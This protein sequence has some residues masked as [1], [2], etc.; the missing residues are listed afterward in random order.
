MVI[1]SHRLSA[2]ID[3]NLIMVMDRGR[4]VDLAP[5][6]TLLERCTIYRSLWAQQNRHLGSG[7]GART[8]ALV[9]VSDPVV[10]GAR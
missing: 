7:M 6:R 5:H 3:C 2:L 8:A 9:S 4:V 10:A 1:V